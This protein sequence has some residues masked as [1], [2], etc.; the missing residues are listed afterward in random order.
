MLPFTQGATISLLEALEAENR[1]R[2]T[3]V[4]AYRKPTLFGPGKA[5]PVV[6]YHPVLPYMFDS[7]LPFNESKGDILPS[8]DKQDSQEMDLDT[9]IDSDC[10]ATAAI[11]T[12]DNT[13]NVIAT[14]ANIN[15]N[16]NVMEDDDNDED[17]DD[18]EEEDEEEEEEEEEEI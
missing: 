2:K 11:S 15:R 13:N 12:N 16:G 5:S 3:V 17:E 18:D 4:L 14:D 7:Y 1:I 10:T 9:I 8:P 6:C